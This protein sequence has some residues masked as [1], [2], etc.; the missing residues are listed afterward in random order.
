MTSAKRFNGC[1]GRAGL[2]LPPL[3]CFPKSHAKFFVRRHHRADYARYFRLA[4]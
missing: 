1:R 2:A 3:V 4:R